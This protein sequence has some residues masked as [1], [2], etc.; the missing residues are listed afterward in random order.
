MIDDD[1]DDR[2]LRWTDACAVTIILLKF[3]C[4]FILMVFSNIVGPTLL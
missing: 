3:H 1:D 4:I 2:L